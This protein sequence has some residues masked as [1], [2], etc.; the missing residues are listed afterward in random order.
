MENLW[1]TS[2]HETQPDMFKCDLRISLSRDEG[3]IN[4]YVLKLFSEIRNKNGRKYP[5]KTFKLYFKY[6][7]VTCEGH[8]S[9]DQNS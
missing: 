3:V 2:F 8:G 5:P 6:N 4:K 7:S 1:I 9:I